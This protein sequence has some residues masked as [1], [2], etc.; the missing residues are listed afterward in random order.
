M[1]WN[2]ITGSCELPKVRVKDQTLSGVGEVQSFNP[3]A[4]EAETT[5]T[6]SLMPVWSID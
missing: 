3:S 6:L 2:W 4:Q 1:P 5:G